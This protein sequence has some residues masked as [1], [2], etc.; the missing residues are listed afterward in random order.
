MPD[1]KKVVLLGTFV[2]GVGV[3]LWTAVF[4]LK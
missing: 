1:P 2:Y 4:M 3:G